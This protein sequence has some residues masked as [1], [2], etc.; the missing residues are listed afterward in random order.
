MAEFVSRKD[1]EIFVAGHRP[2]VYVWTPVIRQPHFPGEL[3][4]VAFVDFEGDP[5][6]ADRSVFL[7]LKVVDVQENVFATKIRRDEAITAHS[8]EPHYFS[9][10]PHFFRPFIIRPRAGEYTVGPNRPINTGT[11]ELLNGIVSVREPQ[12]TTKSIE[13][14]ARRPVDSH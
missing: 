14:G 5:G 8:V 6:T 4:A 3:S 13:P 7:H 12:S 9:G 1:I 11:E 2:V 10:D